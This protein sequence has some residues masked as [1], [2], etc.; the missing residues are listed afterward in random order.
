MA[1]K[2][3]NDIVGKIIKFLTSNKMKTFYWST[4][5]GFIVIA[6]LQ[7]TEIE[8]IYAPILIAILS[9]ITK[10]INRDILGRV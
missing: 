2:L 6:T 7:L 1:K 5:N 9:G 10:Y 8:W 4:V 3:K